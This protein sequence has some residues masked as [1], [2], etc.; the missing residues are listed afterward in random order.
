MDQMGHR[1]DY[2]CDLVQEIASATARQHRHGTRL[3]PDIRTF[4][5]AP[6]EL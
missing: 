6:Q 3:Q 5:R 4:Q 2:V 1:S